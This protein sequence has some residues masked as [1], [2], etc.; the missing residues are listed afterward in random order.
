MSVLWRYF[1]GFGLWLCPGGT[2]GA[3]LEHAPPSW[4]V[5][6]SPLGACHASALD[7][8]APTNIAAP[9]TTPRMRFFITLPFL[10]SWARPFDLPRHMRTRSSPP[11]QRRATG[12]SPGSVQIATQ[13]VVVSVT[14]LS[15]WGSALRRRRPRRRHI[16]RSASRARA[17]NARTECHSMTLISR[18]P[19]GTYALVTLDSPNAGSVLRSTAG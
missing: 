3:E 5:H 6:L 16:C 1:P 18:G 7:A 12:V 19:I 17:P 4:S 14:A 10:A 13:F 11:K 15:Q 9:R 2:P 8:V